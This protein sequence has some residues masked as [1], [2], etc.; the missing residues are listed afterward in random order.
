MKRTVLTAKENPW[1]PFENFRDWKRWE[2]DHHTYSYNIQARIAHTS[3]EL[4]DEENE[5]IIESAIDSFLRN[6]FLGTYKKL[7]SEN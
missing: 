7:Q 6:D 2:D 5:V 4:T 3:R 1:N